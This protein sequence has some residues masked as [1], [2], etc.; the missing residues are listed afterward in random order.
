MANTTGKKFGGRVK[1]T[2]NK[3]STTVKSNVV[4]VFEALNGD[5]LSHMKTWAAENPTQFYNIYAKML[6]T[7]VEATITKELKELTDAELLAI[8][9]GE[10]VTSETESQEQPSQLH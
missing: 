7:E 1:G 4:A 3:I 5:D 6:P 8:A 9:S 10:R 2:P